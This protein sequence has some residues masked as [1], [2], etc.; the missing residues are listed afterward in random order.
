M[1]TRDN[2]IQEWRQTPTSPSAAG[3]SSMTA[4]WSCGRENAGI[5]GRSGFSTHVCHIIINPRYHRPI[6]YW[7]FCVKA[8][9]DACTAGCHSVHDIHIDLNVLWMSFPIIKISIF[10]CYKQSHWKSEL[11]WLPEHGLEERFQ[12]CEIF[13]INNHRCVM[14]R[15]LLPWL[16][17]AGGLLLS[18]CRSRDYYSPL[19]EAP[20]MLA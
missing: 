20:W 12:L 17:F 15:L 2:K 5:F 19:L 1:H 13:G 6:V 14:F 11:V 9:H 10:L 16:L 4:Y 18:C 7:T 3:R 8:R